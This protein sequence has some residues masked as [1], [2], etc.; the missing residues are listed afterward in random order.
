MLIFVIGV[1]LTL[2]TAIQIHFYFSLNVDICYRSKSNVVYG[3]PDTF[4]LFFMLIFVN[5]VYGHPD[6]FLLFFIL[7]FVIGVNLT[8]S[9]AIQIHFY[10]SLY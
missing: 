2:S 4:L 6:T 10:F 1:N 3:H 8:L 5:A 9:T 7:I